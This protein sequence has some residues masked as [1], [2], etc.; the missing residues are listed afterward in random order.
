M[1]PLPIDQICNHF[2]VSRSSLQNLF[3][4]NLNTSPK[5]YINEAKLSLS[6]VL[7]KKGEYTI[8]EISNRLGFTSIHYFSRR[9]TTRYGVTP[10]E[11]AK[12]IYE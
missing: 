3:R 4:N 9:F 10:S 7:I 12:K 6:R 5:H 1:E 8:S 2:S 11:Y